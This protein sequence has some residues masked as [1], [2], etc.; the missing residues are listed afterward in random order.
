MKKY[1][2]LT[3]VILFPLTSSM[4]QYASIWDQYPEDVKKTNAFQRFKWQYQQIAY[5]YDTIPVYTYS[6]ELKKEVNRVNSKLRKTDSEV[7]WSPI[8]PTGIENPSWHSP[9]WGVSSGR[10]R[11]IAVHPTDPLTVYIGAA[12]GGIW[13]TTNGG[14]SWLDIGSNESKMLTFGAIAIDPNNPDVVYAGTGELSAFPSMRHYGKGLFKSTDGGFS[15][16]ETTNVFGPITGFGDVVV[17]PFNSDVLYAALGSSYLFL[18]QIQPNEGVWKSTDGGYYWVRTLD[19]QDAYDVVVHPTDPNL[20]YAAIG[21][22][23]TTSGFYISS[24]AGETWDSS[25]TGLPIPTTISRMQID[26]AKSSPNILYAVIY[27]GMNNTPKAYKTYN[28]GENWEW[29]SQGV[30]LSGYGEGSWYD[31]GDYDLCIVVDPDDPNHVF[32]GNVE[33]HETTNGADFSVKRIPGGYD[34]W[35]SVVHVDYHCLVYSPSNPNVLFIGCDGGIYKSLDDGNTFENLN[36][37]ISTIQFYRIASHPANENI[38]IGG[39]QDNWTSI[40]FDLTSMNPWVAV[41]DGD[42]MECFFDYEYPDTIVY[43]S[44]QNGRL[45]KSTNGGNSF[46]TIANIGGWWITPFFMHPTDHLTLYSAN[47]KIYQTTNGLPPFSIISG[48]DPVVQT[49]VVSISQSKINPNIMILAGGGTGIPL[50]NNP[51][52]KVS[53]DGGYTWIDVTANIPGE[54]RWIPR[55]VTDPFDSSTMYIVRS[56][57]SENNKIYITTDLGNSWTNISGDLPNL[58]C[59]DLFI[60]PHSTNYLYAGLDVGVYRSTDGG[61]S[62]EYVSEDIPLLPVWDFEYVEYGTYAKLRVGTYG[63]S[64]Y[65]TEWSLLQLPSAPILVSPANDT[66]LSPPNV[67]FVWQQSQPEVE[68]YWFELD[69]TEQF[70]TSFIDSTITGTTY[71]YSSLQV[72]KRYWWRVKAYNSAGWGNFSEVRTF[73]TY[74]TSV[75]NKEIPIEYALEQNYPNPFNPVTVIKYSVAEKSNITLRIFNAIGEEIKLL[76][77]E[78]NE[79]GTYETVWNAENLPSGIYFYQL[80]AGNFIE[81]KKMILIK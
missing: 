15:W 48:P 51:E 42:G 52:V 65:E 7:E 81:T 45:R 18:N 2:L 35:K 24:D 53:T 31:Q 69:S 16:I 50:A 8:G 74:V 27:D 1:L 10:V 33:L 6:S 25:N 22:K 20:V 43:S 41:S 39:A 56:G 57:L 49:T 34:L 29:I 66:T 68:R 80:K 55:V 78:T 77:K 19:V 38:M 17:S 67:L 70:S 71:L 76:V 61:D 30:M 64:A 28:G 26:I 62:W 4:S 63:R 46:F 47:N 44:S 79:A 58:P 3:L 14:N 36:N 40:T 73:D 72:D 54:P 5:P 59:W 12:S 21:G 11:A 13:K 75:K 23:F 9:H 60:D 32:I 37:G